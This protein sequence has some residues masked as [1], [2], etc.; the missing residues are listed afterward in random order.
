MKI[1]LSLDYTKIQELKIA[2]GVR[3]GDTI[4]A[5][6]LTASLESIFR[7]TN[8][9]GEGVNIDGEYLNHLRFAYDISNTTEVPTELQ[10]ISDLNKESK[11][12][13]VKMNK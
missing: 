8:W 2:K 4:S 9:E 6:L 10:Q 11:K 12:V 7:K 13:G 1:A 3:Q 5:K